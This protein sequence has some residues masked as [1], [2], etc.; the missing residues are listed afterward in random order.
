MSKLGPFALGLAGGDFSVTS[1]A[2]QIGT[3]ATDFADVESASF[4]V[5]LS[6]GAGGTKINVYIQTS[7]DGGQTFFD[8]ANVAFANTPGVEVINL[9]A[10]DKVTTPTAPTDGTLADNTTLD[11]VLGDQFRA[12]VVSTGIYTGGTLVSVRGVA[13]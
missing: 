4:Q 2:T 11:G 12:K 9:S 10:L 6:G 13:R 3:V 7:L 8:I 5:R 1:A